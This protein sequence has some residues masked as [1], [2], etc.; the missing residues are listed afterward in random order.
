MKIGLVRHLKVMKDYPSASLTQELLFQWI[1]E[2]DSSDVE[3][4]EIHL[5]G[6]HGID[7]FQVICIELKKQQGRS[8]KV[9]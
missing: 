7:V 6:R 2:Y 3:G 4:K 1:Q 9:T 8:L 5:A